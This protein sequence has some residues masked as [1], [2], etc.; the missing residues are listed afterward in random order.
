[1]NFFRSLIGDSEQRLRAASLQLPPY[2]VLLVKDLQDGS[3]SE[4]FDEVT[5]E[6]V[7]QAN[8]VQQRLEDETTRSQSEA[9]CNEERKRL[10]GGLEERNV[11]HNYEKGPPLDRETWASFSDQDGRI[12]NELKLRK[13]V[14][15][16]AA[17]R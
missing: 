10:P 8:L 7:K 9:S 11:R 4:E 12:V 13:C 16:G 15:R 14:F 2:S 1:M 5:M 6:D 3:D 17:K